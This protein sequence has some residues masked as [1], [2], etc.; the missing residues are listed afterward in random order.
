MKQVVAST[1]RRSAIGQPGDLLD[2]L[3]RRHAPDPWNHEDLVQA[4]FVVELLEP[5]SAVECTAQDEEVIEHGVEGWRFDLRL[6]RGKAV[7][8]PTRVRRYLRSGLC[9][10][11]SDVHGSDRREAGRDGPAADRFGDGT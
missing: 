6:Q 10:V 3:G 2:G 9:L 5:L 4:E 8:I 7:D 1:V 11:F